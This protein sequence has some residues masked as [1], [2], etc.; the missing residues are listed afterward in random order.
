MLSVNC[1]LCGKKL[2]EM[3]REGDTVIHIKCS[4]CKTINKINQSVENAET[5]VS[6]T[7]IQTQN[8]G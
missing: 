8:K 7:P 4:K 5:G 2:A 1:F 3:S 6:F